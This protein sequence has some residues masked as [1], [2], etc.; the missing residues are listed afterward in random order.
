MEDKRESGRTVRIKGKPSQKQQLFFD[1]HA[2]YTAYGGA[3]G[4]GKSWALRR[5]LVGLC[6][7]YPGIKCLLIRRSFPEVKTNHLRPLL[8]EYGEILLATAE[9]ICKYKDTLNVGAQLPC[10]V[11]YSGV[12][13]DMLEVVDTIV[14][15]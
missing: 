2:R 7:C 4:G 9:K 13:I 12:N 15:E 1:S 3:R 8:D 5:K 14:I 6:L 10:R 11:T